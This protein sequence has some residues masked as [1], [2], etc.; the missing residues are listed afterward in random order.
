[1][2]RFTN[3]D[4]TASINMSTVM[5]GRGLSNTASFDSLTTSDGHHVDVILSRVALSGALSVL[6][7]GGG[8]LL[9]LQGGGQSALWVLLLNTTL[10]C[11]RGQAV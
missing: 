4:K 7:G 5:L 2:S 10:A 8:T 1:M 9:S 11:S 3:S 6:A